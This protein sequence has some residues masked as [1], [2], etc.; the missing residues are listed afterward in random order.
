MNTICYSVIIS[1]EHIPFHFLEMAFSMY[2]LMTSIFIPVLFL[3]LVFVYIYHQ[4][5]TKKYHPIGGTVFNMFINFKRLHHYMTDLAAKYKT[6]RMISPLHGE[7]YTTDPA[8]VE[9]ILKTNFKN[10]GKGTYTHDWL[11]DFLGDGIFTVDGDKWREQR[12]LSSHEFSTKVLRDFSG[13][14]FRKNAIKVG[15]IFSKAANSNQVVDINDLF[16]KATADSIFK[17]AFGID[18]DNL[19]GTNVEGV[20]F[21]RAFDDANELT[22]NRLVDITWKFKK[23][24]N[25]GS[26]AEL[27][28][29]LKVVDEFVYKVIR[30]KSEQMSKPKD[31]Y[32]VTKED[33]LSRFMQMENRDPKYFRDIVINYVLA[34]KD[35]IAATMTWFI[36]MLCKHPQVQDKVANDIKEAMRMKEDIIN[37]AD[38][39]A[40]VNE[41]T[42]EK[43]QYL[44]ATLAETIRLYPA[45]P[46]DPKI[47]FSDDVLPDGCIVKKGDMISYMPYAMGR[48][49]FIWGDDAQEFKPERWL[50]Q[51][52]C[53]HSQSPFKFTAFQAGPRTCLGREFA[54]RQ[55]KIFSSILLGCFVFKLS[56]ENEDPKYRTTINIQLDGPLNIYVSARSGLHNLES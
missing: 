42:L 18:L 4:S 37:V 44:Q 32:S 40:R 9:Y 27:K 34:G 7:I 39:E 8:I 48:M 6:F 54:Y 43:M 2:F 23:Y 12:K 24:L 28:K 3:L 21:S 35:P 46:M 15:N 13:V 25:I 1:N 26:E 14:T 56:N 31:N 11:E 45:L 30:N 55:M 36:Y 29:N 16:M 53:F 49:K 20:R 52:G 50:D 5:Q 19:S 41:D 10:Y 38:F 47:C 51:N 33:I 22:Y 17:V